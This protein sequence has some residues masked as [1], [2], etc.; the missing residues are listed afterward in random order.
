MPAGMAFPWDRDCLNSKHC[1]DPLFRIK[2][3]SQLIYGIF[4][5]N[6][7]RPALFWRIIIYILLWVFAQSLITSPK[8]FDLRFTWIIK[9]LFAAIVIVITV[10]LRHCVDKRTWAG[11]ALPTPSRKALYNLGS[12]FALGSV[13][14]LIVFGIEYAAG[15]IVGYEFNGGIPFLGLLGGF[16]A[17]MVTGITEELMM[18]GYIFQNINEKYSLW[19]TVLISGILFGTLHYNRPGFDVG[20]VVDAVIIT[21]LLIVTRLISGTI[22]PA[23][24][25]H[26]AWDWWQSNVLGLS[27]VGK[28]DFGHAFLHLTQRGPSIFVG[29]APSIEGGLLII[30]TV[31]SVTLILI[32][33]A[34]YTE[35]HIVWDAKANGNGRIEAMNQGAWFCFFTNWVRALF[36]RR[37]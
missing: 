27:E 15:W 22:W 18:R 37:K 28:S 14:I 8:S 19:V 6:E 24:G 11:M 9:L 23:I 13:M 1:E 26:A 29:K 32:L 7:K 25:W 21:L 20:F 3:P 4:I 16:V 30:S 34:H 12:G 2:D 5:D 17:S 33:M 10:L 31:L 36:L 35:H